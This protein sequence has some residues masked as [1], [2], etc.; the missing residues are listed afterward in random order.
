MLDA[1]KTYIETNIW[2]GKIGISGDENL[3]DSGVLDSLSH[4]QLLSFLEKQYSVSFS[5]RE[6][7]IE[8]F[9]TL[10]KLVAFVESKLS[11]QVGEA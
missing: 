8:N 3:F 2:G 1:I 9:Q 7:R 5:S 11:N 10:N 4:L 6:L